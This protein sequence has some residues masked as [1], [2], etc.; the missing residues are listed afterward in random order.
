MSLE[1]PREHPFSVFLNNITQVD[2]RPLGG[3]P[4]FLLEFPQG[5][6][7][8]LLVLLRFALGNA[9]PAIVP[10]LEERP[11]GM[12]HQHPGQVPRPAIEQKEPSADLRS[13]H[14]R[15]A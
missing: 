5:G 2:E 8:N 6:C 1:G 13:G 14:P 4:R 10:V 15:G 7:E 3:H 9:P 12:S 11:S